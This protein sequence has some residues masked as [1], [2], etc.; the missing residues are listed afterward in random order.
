[1]WKSL[2]PYTPYAAQLVEAGRVLLE[3]LAQ[4]EAALESGSV[5]RRLFH[6]R[7]LHPEEHGALDKLS[8]TIRQ[9]IK[10]MDDHSIHNQM[11]HIAEFRQDS[12]FREFA[13]N[14]VALVARGTYV[15]L[16]ATMTSVVAMQNKLQAKEEKIQD[17]Q[18]Q[19]D[20]SKVLL[21]QAQSEAAAAQEETA[22]AQEE[23]AVAKKE[24]ATVRQKLVQTEQELAHSKSEADRLRD[25]LAQQAAEAQQKIEAAKREKQLLLDQFQRQRQFLTAMLNTN[26]AH[27]LSATSLPEVSAVAAPSS[28]AVSN[29]QGASDAAS[30][31]PT[32]PGMAA[33]LINTRA[34]IVSRLGSVPSSAIITQRPS[35]SPSEPVAASPSEES[36]LS[37][38]APQPGSGMKG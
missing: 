30:A 37:D 36:A 26:V 19:C 7:V 8:Q 32:S 18:K 15:L 28:S 12:P 27:Q 2:S 13:R 6:G 38:S 5:F 31:A 1:V 20:K 4:T 34:A 25:A 17:L 35:V 29:E 22:A 23:T 14:Q 16:H 33:D 9:S 10:S 11:Q 21:A 3:R 24:A